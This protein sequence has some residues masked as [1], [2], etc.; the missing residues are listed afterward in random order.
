[1]CIGRPRDLNGDAMFGPTDRGLSYYLQNGRNE[2]C[3]SREEM[4]R[5][6]RLRK[7]LH[8]YWGWWLA[9]TAAEVCMPCYHL[10]RHRPLKLAA[11]AHH[12]ILQIRPDALHAT[13]I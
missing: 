10:V 13:L 1:M 11:G 5:L 3:I 4:N 6:M 7:L 12:R 2:S 8:L 9:L